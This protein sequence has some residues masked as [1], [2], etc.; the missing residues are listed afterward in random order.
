M[1]ISTTPTFNLKAVI[2][3]TSIAADTLRAWERRYGLPMPERT[4]GGHRL[5][6][7]RDI[8]I[9][10]WLMAK[11]REGLSISRAVD[12]WN[13]LTGSGQDPLPAPATKIT[14]IPSAN[15]DAIRQTW[16]DAC[17]VYDENSAEQLLNQ[18]FATHPLETVCI[19]VM[20]RG[21]QQIGEMW[22]HNQI[23]A[24]QEH[25]TSALVQRRLDALIAAAPP[26]TRPYTILIGCTTGEQHVFVPLLLTLLLRRR[27]LKVVYLGANVPIQRYNETL[28][29]IKPHLV[30]LSAQLL[31]TANDLRETAAYLNANGGRVAYGGR[32]FNQIPQLRNRIP[33]HFLGESIQEAVQAVETL[34]TSDIP[35][36][37]I[38]P[39][40]EKDKQLSRSFIH[41]QP[42]ID[43]YTLTEST[44]IGI[45]IEFS[46]IAIQQLGNNLVSALSLGNI[47]ALEG[48]MAWIEGLLREHDQNIES[49]DVFF[50]AY[51][52]SIDSAMG[53]E[54][55]P[56]SSWLRTQ[57]NGKN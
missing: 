52:K 8:E 2:K 45:P 7:Q 19:E 47:E 41:N 27:G 1:S 36:E 39:V 22:Y 32:I 51:A 5:Y 21:L 50:A 20:Q 16:L 31:Q 18:A 28:Q 6:S 53:K 30:I 10:K 54:G 17:L 24:Q 43:M 49:L 23:N 26:P 56:I 9:I 25:F 12:M 35:L 42:M 38:V 57:I 40:D 44:K 14:T 15:L 34:L 33:A 3:E 4:P 13:E 29:S 11:Q 37:G 48:E 55:Q 46:T